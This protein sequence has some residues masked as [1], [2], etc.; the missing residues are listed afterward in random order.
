MTSVGESGHILDTPLYTG[1]VHARVYVFTCEHLQMWRRHTFTDTHTHTHTQ[2]HTH[3][4]RQTDTCS[5]TDTHT[6]VRTD[7]Q[8]HTHLH[9]TGCSTIHTQLRRIYTNPHT[10]P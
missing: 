8:T 6:H 10:Q 5:Q 9:T 1:L 2:T 7:R 4:H 3:T